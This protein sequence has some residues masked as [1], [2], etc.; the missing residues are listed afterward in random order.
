MIGIS[1]NT[2]PRILH[3]HSSVASAKGEPLVSIV[4]PVYNNVEYIERAI[5]SILRNTYSNIEVIL[6]DDGST[7]G[8]SLICDSYA[9]RDTRIQVIHQLNSGVS[10]ARNAGIEVSSGEYIMFVDSDDEITVSSICTLLRTARETGA[11]ITTGAIER[12]YSDAQAGQSAIKAQVRSEILDNRDGIINFLS[13]GTDM[14]ACARLYKTL[15]IKKHQFTMNIRINEDKLFIFQALKDA[16]KSAY[17]ESVVYRYHQIDSSTTHSGFSEKYF[18]IE[19]VADRIFE[20]TLSS[21]SDL[22]EIAECHHLLAL[23]ELYTHLA[24]SS[25]AR[26]K[27][28]TRHATIRNRILSHKIGVLNKDFAKMRWI[29][30]KISP[31]LYVL[32]SILYRKLHSG[33][34]KIDAEHRSSSIFANDALNAMTK[35]SI[36]RVIARFSGDD[37]KH[38]HNGQDWKRK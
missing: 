7:D 12:V 14:T 5:Q 28:K 10:S 34:P 15:F 27:Y 11:E 6:V 17:I 16:Q 35:R 33:H 31:V 22:K 21:Y 36:P 24:L 32:L 38:L 19:I 20:G 26:G 25:Y 30:I 13:G 4:V 23:M 1:D 29:V 3:K 9:T 37:P 18:D 8:S 2:Y